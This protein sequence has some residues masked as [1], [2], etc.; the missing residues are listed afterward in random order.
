MKFEIEIEE[1]K[2]IMVD[3]ILTLD[4]VKRLNKASKAE[5]I[6][7]NTVGQKAD[8]LAQ[9]NDNVKIRVIGGY[10]ATKYA[11]YKEPK[12]QQRTF[13]KPKDLATVV[14]AFE[15]MENNID[16]KWTDTEKALFVYIYLIKNIKYDYD[17]KNND[18]NSNLLP[19]LTHSSKCAGFATC[20][21][22]AMDRLD[23]ENEFKN[24]P[25]IHSFNFVKLNKHWRAVDVT[26]GRNFIDQEQN[27]KE[28]LQYFGMLPINSKSCV[29]LYLLTDE[30]LQKAKPFTK[31]E[32][33]NALKTINTSQQ[34]V[35]TQDTEIEMVR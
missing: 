2:M 10:D 23:I 12:Y 11:K 21:K 20:Y 15:T 26:W 27:T 17:S 3:K 6:L 22:E 16:K 1:E 18:T 29:F 14:R 30:P 25:G 5:V 9:L 28:F 7:K 13:Y 34:K 35:T 19:I 4:D 33:A 8:I 24:V 31:R 32:V